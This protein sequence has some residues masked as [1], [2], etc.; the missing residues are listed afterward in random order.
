MEGK[1]HVKVVSIQKNITGLFQ[2][3]IIRE[4]DIVEISGNRC[5]LSVELKVSGLYDVLFHVSY[6]SDRQWHDLNDVSPL[7]QISTEIG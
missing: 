6:S 4:I 7:V 5:T 1:A 2:P 3:V